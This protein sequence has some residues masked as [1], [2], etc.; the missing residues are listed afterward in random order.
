MIRPA[1]EVEDLSDNDF[2]KILEPSEKLGL[3][4]LKSRISYI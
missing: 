1:R 2:A 3:R 4:I